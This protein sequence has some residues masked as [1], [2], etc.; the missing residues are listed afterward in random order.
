MVGVE[1]DTMLPLWWYQMTGAEKL[2][3]SLALMA[4]IVGVGTIVLVIIQVLIMRRQTA[5]MHEQGEIAKRQE[6]ISKRQ[7]EIAEAQHKIM[8]DQLGRRA[9]LRFAGVTVR[10]TAEQTIYNFS[11]EN[12]GSRTARDVYWHLAFPVALLN[13]SEAKF[14]TEADDDY[15]TM[16]GQEWRRFKHLAAVP[17]FPTRR[18]LVCVLTVDKL[19]IAAV[20]SP[21]SSAW[22][23]KWML[24]SEDGVFP[25]S[26]AG[27][28]RP[29]DLILQTNGTWM[30]PKD[31]IQS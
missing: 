1:S 7:G 9:L 5:M 20:G 24:V 31:S 8:E 18:I 23:A 21:P 17:V 29:A 4:V 27:E 30:V 19:K 13:I 26:Q 12:Y 28:A 6:A 2:G 3:T 14:T 25:P 15:Q 16:D 10:E 11:V 22:A